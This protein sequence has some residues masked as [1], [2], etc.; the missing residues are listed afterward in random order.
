MNG[1]RRTNLA[2]ATTSGVSMLIAAAGSV[3][4]ALAGFDLSPETWPSDARVAIAGIAACT[5]C[6]ASA[7]L[8]EPALT[9]LRRRLGLRT[10]RPTDAPTAPSLDESVDLAATAV[11]DDAVIRAASA[12]WHLDHSYGF[13]DHA[14]QWQGHEDGTATYYLAP[15][16]LLHHRTERNGRGLAMPHFTLL[17][18]DD[19]ELPVDH[20]KEIH[21]YLLTRAARDGSADDP[22]ELPA[23]V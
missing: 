13:L 22:T 2:A 21:A 15:G 6:A 18:G 3:I 16:I 14:S 12:A 7:D 19:R 20:V 1:D 4:G 11:K 9:W 5:V 17:T 8:S 23:T 10:G